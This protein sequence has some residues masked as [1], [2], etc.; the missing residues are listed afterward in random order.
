MGRPAGGP[1][2]KPLHE[3]AREAQPPPRASRPSRAT[4]LLLLVM[5]LLGPGSASQAV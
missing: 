4:H 3:L 5:L 2:G 1:G